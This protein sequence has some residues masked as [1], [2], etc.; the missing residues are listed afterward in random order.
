MRPC[1][2][3]STVI[4]LSPFMLAIGV[5]VYNF[6]LACSMAIWSRVQLCMHGISTRMEE[7]L[8]EL[9][10]HDGEASALV[11]QGGR[12]LSPSNA[13]E[14]P[15]SASTLS[16]LA[17]QGN[18]AP[19]DGRRGKGAGRTWVNV[20]K[21]VLGYL[22]VGNIF[23]SGTALQPLSCQ[24]NVD[25]SW[26]MT[27]AAIKC[28]LCPSD[29]ATLSSSNSTTST[30]ESSSNSTWW[31]TLDEYKSL[32]KQAIVCS[33]LYGLGS[34]LLFFTVLYSHRHVLK[35]NEFQNAFGF[36]SSKMREE[37]YYWEVVISFRKLLLVCAARLFTKE[38]RVPGALWVVSVT[39][40]A[41][42]AQ[43]HAS[44]FASA[45]DLSILLSLLLPT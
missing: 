10:D 11:S 2:C 1:T 6:V 8:P 40:C 24:Q 3:F 34:P 39:V 37:F 28:D 32:H 45:F 13:T 15:D 16:G 4:M 38:N 21:I 29:T 25:G 5:I 44:P 30:L 27:T 19:D 23:L 9:L 18:G 33:T 35:K 31:N 12:D 17:V 20:Q 36:L 26:E 22:M 41:L 43:V 14:Q 7:K 42:V